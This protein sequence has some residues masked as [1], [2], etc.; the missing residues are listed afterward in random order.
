MDLQLKGK[1]ALVTGSSAGIGEGI[2][3]ALAREGVEV[4]VHGRN[5]AGARAVADAIVSDGSHRT[6]RPCDRRQCIR[7]RP[8]GPRH[9]SP[10]HPRQQRR[11]LRDHDV[12]Y[13][14]GG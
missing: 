14:S 10:P 5:E 3:K 13:G 1:R 11:H 2:A 6:R 9:R 12:G 8:E 4:I 7:G